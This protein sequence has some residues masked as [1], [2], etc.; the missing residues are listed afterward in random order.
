MI[1][2][3][4][5]AWRVDIMSPLPKE[6]EFLEEALNVFHYIQ[7]LVLMQPTK[8]ALPIQFATLPAEQFN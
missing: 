3:K 6:T 5:I 2:T 1:N 4:G 8:S 7:P